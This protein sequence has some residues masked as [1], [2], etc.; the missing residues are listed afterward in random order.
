MAVVE[1]LFSLFCSVMYL[2]RRWRAARAWD[3]E[4]GGISTTTPTWIWPLLPRR[5][6]PGCPGSSASV[7]VCACVLIA[8]TTGG[9]AAGIWSTWRRSQSQLG[10]DRGA[11][12]LTSVHKVRINSKK[13]NISTLFWKGLGLN[14]LL[15]WF[16]KKYSLFLWSL[17]H[18][19]TCHCYIIIYYYRYHWCIK[20]Y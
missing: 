18:N 7:C 14:Y 4:E 6:S 12:P 8:V 16:C 1:S 17:G 15:H 11:G 10:R 20:V 13:I 3:C 9:E 19:S 5:L 2:A